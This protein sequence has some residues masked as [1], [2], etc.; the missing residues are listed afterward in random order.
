MY[1][2][3]YNE[4]NL[5][6]GITPVLPS[7]FRIE[8][9]LNGMAMENVTYSLI[10]DG[11]GT[12]KMNEDTGAL[13][14]QAGYFF[15][16]EN[17]TQYLLSSKCRLEVDS[18]ELSDIGQ[19]NFNILPVNEFKPQ[20]QV[21][22][23]PGKG[24]FVKVNELSEIG[25]IIATKEVQPP[26]SQAIVYS[27]S[28]D[29]QG[30]EENLYTT[31]KSGD[32]ISIF[33][34][35]SS[36]TVTLGQRLD[37]DRLN[38]NEA[39]I[40]MQIRV[41][42]V[43]PPTDANCNELVLFIVTIR[44]NDNDPTFSQDIYSV[45]VAES[46]ASNGFLVNVS[47]IDK[48]IGTGEFSNVT[49]SSSSFSVFF[50]PEMSNQSIYHVAPLDFESVSIHSIMLTCTDTG[51]KNTTATLIVNVM[52]IN[53]NQPHFSTKAYSFQIS[54]FSTIG[55]EV[56]RLEGIDK[57]REV[58]NQLIYTWTYNKN[59]QL[60]KEDGLII[61]RDFVY[62]VE[63]EAFIFDAMVTDGEFNDTATVMIKINGILS[64]PEVILICMGALIF[65]VLVVSIIVCCCY[66]CICCSRL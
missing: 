9:L 26:E 66:C 34:V 19:I 2:F 52:A 13:S 40:T 7:H 4:T 35:D 32:D 17:I 33:N 39:I 54:R 63:S 25:Q 28:D 31:L 36:G 37:L 6:L 56:G 38:L 8:C 57:D 47:C 51:G 48:D 5:T 60:I 24:K 50:S 53:D 61:L 16:Y 46:Y 64:V 59:F 12:F 11:G 18:E 27:V 30:Q 45:T 1:T 65:I 10:S 3:E 43:N 20:I 23:Q 29:D 58:G 22:Q 44:S 55:S 21:T 41:C 14:V 42:D 15:D 62:A 49:S